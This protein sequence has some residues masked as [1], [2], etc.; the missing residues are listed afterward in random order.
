MENHYQVRSA[1]PA[2]VPALSAIERTVFADPWTPAAFRE[3]LGP[4]SLVATDDGSVTGYVFARVMS[5]EA[6]VLNLAVRK[7]VQ[8]KGIG[9]HLLDAIF[10]SFRKRGVREVYLEVRVSNAAGQAFY[11]RLG[12]RQV[13]RR[14]SYYDKPR[15]DALILAR[16]LDPSAKSA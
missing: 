15:E 7:D 6:E 10:E 14:R 13:G 1:T 3:L 5:D 16:Q 9:R 11:E 4:Y 8:R 2:D 12:F